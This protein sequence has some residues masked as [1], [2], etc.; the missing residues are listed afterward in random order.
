M[1]TPWEI[2]RKLFICSAAIKIP[3]FIEFDEHSSL[4]IIDLGMH[5]PGTTLFM[6]CAFLADVKLCFW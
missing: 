1:W 6:N 3:S 4:E 5:A 2:P